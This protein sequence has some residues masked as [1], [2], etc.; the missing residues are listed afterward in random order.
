M[1]TQMNCLSIWS[2]SRCNHKRTNVLWCYVQLDMLLTFFYFHVDSYQNQWLGHR[3]FS[4][5]WWSYNSWKYVWVNNTLWS[6]TFL[7]CHLRFNKLNKEPANSCKPWFEKIYVVI[8]CIF[9]LTN[10]FIFLP[11]NWSFRFIAKNF[12]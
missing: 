12:W 2:G 3:G 6:Y 1:F 9:I 11:V 8:C 7:Y 5:W 10:Y 4:Y